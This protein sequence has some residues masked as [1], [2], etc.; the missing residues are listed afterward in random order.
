MNVD[1]RHG[2][3]GSWELGINEGHFL[4]YFQYNIS[5]LSVILM[6]IFFSYVRLNWKLCLNTAPV[7]AKHSKWIL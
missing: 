4:Y 1:V 6:A 3:E 7:A 5:I 2:R